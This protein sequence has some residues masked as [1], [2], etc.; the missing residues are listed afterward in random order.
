MPAPSTPAPPPPSA[1]ESPKRGLKLSTT[2]GVGVGMAA[3]CIIIFTIIFVCVRRRR[4]KFGFKRKERT[5][6][7]PEGESPDEEIVKKLKNGEADVGVTE[8]GGGDVVRQKGEAVEADGHLKRIDEKKQLVGDRPI[9]E[10]PLGTE[11]EVQELPGQEQ[12]HEVGDGS[13]FIAELDS[14]EIERRKT[15]RAA[16]RP[17]QEEEVAPPIPAKENVVAAPSAG[18]GGSVPKIVVEES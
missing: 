2:I 17:A 5:E 11:T 14:K 9:S 1:T 3:V 8:M 16:R 10:L 15:L 12:A 4:R 6:K 13:F 7:T 18:P